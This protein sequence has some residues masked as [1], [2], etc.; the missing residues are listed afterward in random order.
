MSRTFK[1]GFGEDAEELLEY[2][3]YDSRV[4]QGDEY[5]MGEKIMLVDKHS[6][7]LKAERPFFIV[8]MGAT[9]CSL[10]CLIGVCLPVPFFAKKMLTELIM[11]M[12]LFGAALIIIG[13][14]HTARIQ[15]EHEKESAKKIECDKHPYILN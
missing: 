14:R 13:A 1:T 2:E 4:R 7:F 6:Y 11:W 12:A 15:K 3:L 5:L 8:G 10:I 9:A